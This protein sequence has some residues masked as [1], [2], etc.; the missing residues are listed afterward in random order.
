MKMRRLLFCISYLLVSFSFAQYTPMPS[1][2]QTKWKQ[3]NTVFG[4]IK[5][6]LDNINS[7][8]TLINNKLYQKVYENAVVDSNYVGAYRD[9]GNG[10]VFFIGLPGSL[11]SNEILLYDFTLEIG[12]TIDLIPLGNPNLTKMTPLSIGCAWVKNVQSGLLEE[13]KILG[14]KWLTNTGHGEWGY[15]NWIE[16]LGST[17]GL[18]TR[19]TPFGW[20]FNFR[21][22]NIYQ[23]GDSIINYGYFDCDSSVGTES[24]ESN[25]QINVYPN[26]VKN[27][28][29]IEFDQNSNLASNFHL[30]VISVLG[31]VV[32]SSTPPTNLN[33]KILNFDLS[34]LTS[35]VYLL[36]M[37]NG[38][39]V[40]TE[41]VVVE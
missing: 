39:E 13:R 40:Y 14:M 37:V 36:R 29:N 6:P 30:D 32:Y 31:K 5:I 25:V 10:K 19:G 15:Y 17:R 7:G 38:D 8:D 18:L 26:P 2:V 35:G 20:D 34:N 27:I 3:I 28:L 41:Q 11:A 12:D 33:S 24:F 16:G 23:L 1:T 21:L 9:D 22:T 4:T